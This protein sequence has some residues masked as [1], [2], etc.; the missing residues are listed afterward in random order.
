M[1]AE[2]VGMHFVIRIAMVV[3]V[4]GISLL[5]LAAPAS[6][7]RWND[8]PSRVSVYNF[9]IHRMDD[10]WGDWVRWVESD[11]GHRP[12]IFL[13][14]DMDNDTERLRFQE[15]LGK[16]WGGTWYGRRGI[17]GEGWHTAIIWRAER[18]SQAKSRGWW[19]FGDADKSA[20]ATCTDQADGSASDSANGAPAV[21]VRLFDKIGSRY[22]SAVSFKTPGASPDTC[23]WLN[24]RKVNFKLNEEGWSGGLL[25]MGTDSNSRD[26]DAASDGSGE[27][28]CWYRGTNGDLGGTGCGNDKNA[29][30]GFRDPIFQA[31]AGK[32]SCLDGEATRR[33]AR[34]DYIFAKLG[35]G[36]MPRTSDQLTLPAAGPDGRYSDHRAIRSLIYY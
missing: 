3:V 9:N 25:L 24:T 32:R 22:V 14:Q 15:F 12:D 5:Q 2:G 18:F 26:W 35:E 28:R 13:V 4:G 6:A 17:P 19:G 21:Q 10:R 8:D 31:C 34:I 23:A 27:W 30:Q 29:N 20:P 36:S 7:A 33:N 16:K 11:S 1:N